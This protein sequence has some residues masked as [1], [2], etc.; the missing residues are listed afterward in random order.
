MAGLAVIR[1]AACALALAALV[2]GCGR[3]GEGTT[4]RF[5]AMGRE[6][7]VLA[8]L[9]PEFERTHPGIH[10]RVEQ[11]P[12]TAAHEKLLTAVAGDATPDLCQLGNTWLPELAALNALAPLEARIAAS[13]GVPR[14]DY[15]PGIWATNVIG[16]HVFGV[17]WYVDTRLLF[18]RRDLVAAAGYDHPPRTWDEL[19][20]EAAA[21]QARGHDAYGILLPLNEYEPLLAFG[22]QQREGLLRED[23]T[24]GNFSSAAFRRT[25]GFY[26]SMFKDGLAPPVSNSQIANVWTEFGRGYF[27]FYISGPWNIGEFNRRLP[28]ALKGRWETAPL[29][30]PEGPSA[31]IA[32]GASLAVFRRSA[33]PD[34]AWQLVEYLSDPAVQA[35]FHALTGDLPA[36]RSAWSAPG[37]AAD[38]HT[39]AFADQ[40][41]RVKPTPPVPEWEEMMTEMRVVA[42]HVVRGD[43]SIEEGT[44]ELDRRADRMLRKRRELVAEGHAP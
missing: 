35:R 12:W 27:A 11:L 10:V 25:L 16:G 19:K 38:S 13:R 42:E 34:E 32:G 31:A 40:L 26:V 43:T 15:F 21:V 8:E 33:H 24:R 20:A 2:A 7:E 30:G 1:V 37:I 4:L 29:P 41:E 36:R 14:A 18:Y 5:W 17:P 44:A 9:M 22:L 23:N 3:A 6:A 28:E 39:A